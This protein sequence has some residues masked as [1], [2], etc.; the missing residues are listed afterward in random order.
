VTLAAKGLLV[1]E[2]RTNIAVQS[3]D[4]STTW[5]KTSVVDAPNAIIS[6]DGTLTGDGMLASTTTSTLKRFSQVITVVNA[7]VYTQSVYVKAGLATTLNFRF[8]AGNNVS[9]DL[10]AKTAT[11]AGAFFTRAS[12]LDAG[13]GWYRCDATFTSTSTSYTLWFGPSAANTTYASTV[14]PILY[15]WGAQLELG[16]FSTSLVPTLA[17]AVARAIEIVPLGVSEFP[18]SVSEGTL[19]AAGDFVGFSAA[20]QPTFV[21][22]TDGIATASPSASWVNI[23]QDTSNIVASRRSS[24]TTATDITASNTQTVNVVRKVGLAFK[25]SGTDALSVN[26]AAVATQPGVAAAYTNVTLKIGAFDTASSPS[27]TDP[28]YLNGHVRQIT[29]IPRQVS[30]AELEARTA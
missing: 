20:K 1:E 2:G 17:T 9:F 8:D 29:Y 10:S 26:G 12:I 28:F 22:I 18:Y 30:N 27:A 19:V 13:N 25:Q 24:S 11:I 4:F 3:N 16:S 7:T 21:S 6:P 15:L 14:T 5:T 23:S